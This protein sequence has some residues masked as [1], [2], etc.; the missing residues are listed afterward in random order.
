MSLFQLADEMNRPQWWTDTDP[1]KIPEKV[2][3]KSTEEL[4]I[5]KKH[6]DIK[7]ITGDDL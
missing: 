2:L 3:E 4:E 1:D 7:R 6:A 5:A